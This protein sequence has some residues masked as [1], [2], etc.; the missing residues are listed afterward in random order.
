LLVLFVTDIID[1]N[2][3]ILFNESSADYLS[4]A[5]SIPTIKEGIMIKGVVSRK[6]QM[7]PVIMEVLEKA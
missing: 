4:D 5:F 6:K 3:Y 2:S 1:N 7:V